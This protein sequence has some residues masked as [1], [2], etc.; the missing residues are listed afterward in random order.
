MSLPSLSLQGK[1]AFPAVTLVMT[2]LAIPFAVTTGRRGALYGIGLAIVLSVA[3][4]LSMA[5]FAAAGFLGVGALVKALAKA[6]LQV[7]LVTPLY[8]GIPERFPDLHPFGWRMDLPLGAR[9][10]QAEVFK[11]GRMPCQHTTPR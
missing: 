7:G 5:F 1:I 10:V 8:K 2:F 4:W 11:R 3:Y 9:R 6:G